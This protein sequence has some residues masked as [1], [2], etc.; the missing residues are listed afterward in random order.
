M[1]TLHKVPA[2]RD[3]CRRGRPLPSVQKRTGFPPNARDLGS[4]QQHLLR[5]HRV[6]RPAASAHTRRP[7]EFPPRV[8][9]R[10]RGRAPRSMRPFD[11]GGRG[12]SPGE[13]GTGDSPQRR[14][15]L[16]P[17]RAQAAHCCTLKAKL[18]AVFKWLRGSCLRPGSRWGVVVPGEGHSRSRWADSGPRSNV[19]ARPHG[20]LHTRAGGHC[21]DRTPK[22]WGASATVPGASGDRPAP[23]SPTSPEGGAGGRLRPKPHPVG[24]QSCDVA[25][26]GRSDERAHA[27]QAPREDRGPRPTPTGTPG[28]PPATCVTHA[29]LR[30]SSRPADDAR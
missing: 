13:G 12:Q 7:R 19:L 27:P 29:T 15:G 5:G 25:G 22:V 3:A 23:Q 24:P 10:R 1:R 8:P 26:A 30:A 6:P 11:P 18:A 2:G 20:P 4:P 9:P 14:V 17:G 16:A 21:C 28:R